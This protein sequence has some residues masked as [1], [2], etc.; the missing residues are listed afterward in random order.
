MPSSGRG[1]YCTRACQQR[2]YRLRHTPGQAAL[3]QAWARQ[4]AEQ[5]LLVSQTIYECPRC[6]QRS[7]GQRRCPDCNLMG[8]K[9][10][11]G[12]DCPHCDELLLVTE[13]LGDLLP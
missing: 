11:L 7:L 5:R 9:L 3:L 2:A 1:R 8:R 4:L 6:E 13:L 10:G 12:G